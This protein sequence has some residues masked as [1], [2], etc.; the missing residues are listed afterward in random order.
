MSNL[1]EPIEIHDRHWK[2]PYCVKIN[3]EVLLNFRGRLIRYKDSQSAAIAGARELDRRKRMAV[4]M[5][6]RLPESSD[7]P[8]YADG[9]K[10]V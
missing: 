4:T 3:G 9:G 10:G 6:S 7:A 5:A 1:I 8:K 2:R